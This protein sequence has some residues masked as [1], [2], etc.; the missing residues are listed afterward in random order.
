MELHKTPRLHREKEARRRRG[1]KRGEKIQ[2]RDARSEIKAHLG[3]ILL[4]IINPYLRSPKVS[5]ETH[6]V[7]MMGASPWRAD[8]FAEALFSPPVVRGFGV[9]LFLYFRLLRFCLPPLMNNGTPA[10]R[11]RALHRK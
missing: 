3:G 10:T 1:A 9:Y 5:A 8:T 7:C 11:R 2:T 4:Q 6:H